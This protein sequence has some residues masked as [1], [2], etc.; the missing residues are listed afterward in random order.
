MRRSARRIAIVLIAMTVTAAGMVGAL[1]YARDYNVHRG[2]GTVVQ[3]RRAGT[4]RLVKVEFFSQ[5]L[6]RTADYLVYLPP[7]YSVARRYPVYY[8]LHGMPGQPRVFVDIANLD[9]RLDNQLSLRRAQPMILV[10]PDGRIANS[11]FSDSEWANTRSGNFE[12][13]VIDVMHNVDDHYA[14]L[15]HR[16]DRVIAGFSAGGYGAMNI[17]LHH[18]ADFANVQVWSGYFTQTDTGVFAHAGHAALADNSPRDAIRTMGRALRRYPLRTYLFSGRDDSDS[19]QLLPMA[20]ALSTRGVHVAYR[21]YPGGHDWSVWY[22]RL[23]QMLDLASW[24]IVHPPRDQSAP[25]VLNGL[26]RPPRR[27][28]GRGRGHG[29]PSWGPQRPFIKTLAAPVPRLVDHPAA[30]PH[31][32][33]VAHPAVVAHARRHRR[34]SEL[35][36]IGVL[37]LALASAALIN[38]GFV[39]QHRGRAHD[40]AAGRTSLVHA[41]HN[42]TW[43]AGQAVGWIGFAGQIV[44]V[45]LAPLTLVQAFAAGSLAISVPVAARILGQRVGRAQLIAVAVVAVS[46]ASLPVGLGHHHGHLQPGAL[47]I[48]ALVTVLAAMALALRGRPFLQAIASG[49]LYGVADAAIKADAVGLRIHGPSA[50]LSGWTILAALATFGGFLAFQAALRGRDAVQPLS[51]MNAFTAVTAVALGVGGFGE[52]LGV[53]PAATVGHVIAIALVL[54]CV[55][56]LTRAQEHMIH[57]EE[58]AVDEAPIAVPGGAR[59]KAG[60]RRDGGLRGIAGLA[61]AT[62]TSA[63]ATVA[64]VIGTLSGVGLLYSLR[65]LHWL[66][67]GPSIPDALPLLQLAGFAGQPAARVIVAWIPAGVVLGLALI[68]FPAPRRT[69]LILMFGA[70]L[71]LFASDASYALARNLRFETVLL[72]REPGLGPWVECLLLAA[73]GVLP[74]AWSRRRPRAAERGR[75]PAHS[76]IPMRSA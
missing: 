20:R 44:A 16:R 70:V 4:G 2:F 42:R 60:E 25:L 7:H 39:L 64:V 74:W 30:V 54:A 32:A 75:L 53:S 61:R 12:S 8:L 43:L 59:A 56:P 27:V 38:L 33:A 14:T 62:V 17:A 21:F 3:F 46:L 13:Y 73:G 11:T 34:R 50:L 1:S 58:P 9:I 48:A 72:N 23:D 51:L 22:P 26:G 5:A 18:L 36:L 28:F 57:G 66:T 35:H 6:R 63:G 47:L 29:R 41:L 37:L 31:L 45:A 40:L 49:G 55:R 19:R 24:D 65:Q 15:R 10:Y 71:L 76:T 52:S 68:R 69:L 67:A